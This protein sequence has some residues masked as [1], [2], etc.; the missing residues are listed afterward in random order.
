VCD[1]YWDDTDAR[2]VCR[3]LGFTGGQGVS[4]SHFG[5]AGTDFA[6]DDVLCRG[7]ETSILEC[8]HIT[9]HN[10]GVGEAAG[11]ICEDTDQGSTSTTTTVTLVG[12]SFATEGNVFINGRAVCDDFWSQ[13]DA[14]VICKM[15][16]FIGGTPTEQSYFGMVPSNFGM[17]NVLCD[18]TES[19]ILDCPHDTSHNCGPNEGAGVMCTQVRLIGGHEGNVLIGN[20]PVCDDF[21]DESD[22][23]VVCRMLGF[24]GGVPKSGSHFGSVST[25]FAMDDVFCT[26]SETSILDCPH[27]T[28]HNCEADEAAGVICMKNVEVSPLPVDISNNQRFNWIYND[29]RKNEV[30][31]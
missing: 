20:Q 11:V 21:W 16:G 23:I 12:G 13:N 5:S 14:N 19:D 8:L 15:L 4:Q 10:C 25:D 30:K 1:D 27:S 26:G 7:R 2:V 28:S 3:I 24:S 6:M 9:E 17:D 29:W 22:A 31:P 18:G